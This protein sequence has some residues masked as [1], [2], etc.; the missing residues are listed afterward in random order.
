MKTKQT[1]IKTA[2]KD[3][4]TDFGLGLL[5][6]TV[7]AL[8]L[9]GTSFVQQAKAKSLNSFTIGCKDCNPKLEFDLS[10]ELGRLNAIE[11]ATN[12]IASYEKFHAECYWDVSGY[13]QG[14][15]HM[16][17]GGKVSR[18]KSKSIL[19]KE[20]VKLFNHVPP[21]FSDTQ[22]IGIVSFLYNHPVNQGKYIEMLWSDPERFITGLQYKAENYTWIDGVRY[23]GLKP[24]RQDEY[25]YVLNN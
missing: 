24:R 8:C 1:N 4:A 12:F 11:E 5:T 15:G 2:L 6:I 13:T 23:G 10:L 25:M 9:A 22:A 7:F 17:L 19:R 21:S 14:Y 18:T 3:D 16:C 20:V